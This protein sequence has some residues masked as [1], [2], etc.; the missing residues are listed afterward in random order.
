MTKV[1]IVDDDPVHRML[2]ARLAEQVG[3]QTS[4]AANARDA[5]E[6]LSQEDFCVMTLDLNLGEEDGTDVLEYLA[7]RAIE[8]RVFVISGSE[9]SQYEAAVNF[10]VLNRIDIVDF[11]K[12]IQLPYLRECLKQ[13]ANL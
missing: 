11:P 5:I 9:R 2:I 10:G 6:K 12:P 3:L 1:L 7:D 4:F 8:M 13:V